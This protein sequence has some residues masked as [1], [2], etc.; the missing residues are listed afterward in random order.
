MPSAAAKPAV[1]L[2]VEDEPIQRKD[3]ED[4][5]TAEG[6]VVVAARNAEQ[7][8]ATLK[9]RDDIN[10]VVT[11]VRMPGTFDGMVVA[12]HAARAHPVIMI[13]AYVL[14]ARQETPA[15]DF[16][17]LSKP[18]NRAALLREVRRAVERDQ[19]LNA[20]GPRRPPKKRQRGRPPRSSTTESA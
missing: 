18:L 4:I 15:Q 1:I 10:V 16:C 9:K 3:I 13:S 11:D 6:Y 8:L 2:V 17:L 14:A 12:W 7:A 5:L 19:E 20:A